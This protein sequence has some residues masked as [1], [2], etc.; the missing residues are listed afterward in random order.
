[1]PL[2][3]CGDGGKGWRWGKSGKCYLGPGAKKKAIKQGLAVEGPDKFKKVASLAEYLTLFL[4]DEDLEEVE[5]IQ[6]D[7]DYSQN[8]PYPTLPT[9]ANP[10]DPPAHAN[11]K[12]FLK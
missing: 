4:A 5:K 8:R 11:L 3:R 1:M 9:S 12:Q 6:H 7:T 2:Q 10:N